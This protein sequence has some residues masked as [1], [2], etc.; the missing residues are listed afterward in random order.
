MLEHSF[1]RLFVPWN[2]RSHAG[3]F[4]LG[5][6]RSL[7]HSFPGPFVPGTFVPENE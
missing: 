2:I 5:T 1:S 7:E 6:T 4:I 3:T